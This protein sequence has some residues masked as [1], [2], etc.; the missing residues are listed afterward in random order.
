MQRCTRKFRWDIEKDIGEL[1]NLRQRYHLEYLQENPLKDIW[2]QTDEI[3]MTI[4]NLMVGCLDSF[5]IFL[6][7][8]QERW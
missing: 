2:D 1:E 4:E 3:L 6:G 5:S 7:N 8:Q